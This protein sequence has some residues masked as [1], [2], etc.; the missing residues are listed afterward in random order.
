MHRY[1]NCPGTDWLH[2]FLLE[3]L[4]TDE[5]NIEDDEWDQ[6]IMFKQ[7]STTDWAELVTRTEPVRDYVDLLVSHLNKSTELSYTRTAQS[8]Y[9][10]SLKETLPENE[11][12]VLGDFVENYTF[13]MQDEIQGMH[14]NN[15]QCSL[16]PIVIYCRKLSQTKSHF[17]C[18]ISDDLMYDVDFVCI[19]IKETVVF[20]KN[21]ILSNLYYFFDGFSG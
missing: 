5:N 16:H 11:F 1:S 14:S 21:F 19:V 18:F 4:D 3:K 17:L 20:I 9:L 7:W 8:N 13:L 10:K 2:A 12:V 15:Q 6:T